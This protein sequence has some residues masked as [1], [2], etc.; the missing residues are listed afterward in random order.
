M[1][2]L[3]S[4]SALG[5]EGRVFESLHPDHLG[6]DQKSWTLRSPFFVSTGM[7][8]GGRSWLRMACLSGYAAPS[9]PAF[10]PTPFWWQ[11]PAELRSAASQ[12]PPYPAS[13]S[14]ELVSGGPRPPVRVRGWTRPPAAAP[15]RRFPS[16]H[17]RATL[18][19]P[20]S[21]RLPPTLNHALVLRL[22]SAR[23]TILARSH[24]ATP[25]HLLAAP[26]LP[27]TTEFSVTFRPQHLPL[28]R[29]YIHLYLGAVFPDFP[30]SCYLFA[31]Q[32]S[33]A[34]LLMHL[35]DL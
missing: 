29:R 7:A 33:S 12:L 8:C 23:P 26:A 14:A 13:R 3:A 35:T 28:A 11:P 18:W 34:F 6:G 2:Q 32:R 21:P 5:A 9:F 19:P 22:G 10:Q 17:V 25:D 16:G 27:A 30:R 4:A 1:A 20:H 15:D 31:S 24:L